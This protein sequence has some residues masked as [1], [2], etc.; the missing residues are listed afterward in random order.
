ML[1]KQQVA[2][3]FSKSAKT[4][5]KISILQRSLAD[6]LFNGSKSL[7]PKNILDLGC[8]TGYLAK[9]LAKKFKKAK[10]IGIDLASGMIKEAK[11]RNQLQNIKYL[12]QDCEELPKIGR[13][14]LIISNASLQWMDLK[15][16]SLCIKRNLASNGIFMFNTF[17]PKNLIELQ[18]AGFKRNIFPSSR[19]IKKIFGNYFKIIKIIRSRHKQKFKNIQA[20]VKHLKDLGANT[21]ALKGKPDIKR[22]RAILKN[23]PT[24]FYATFDVYLGIL[25]NPR[26]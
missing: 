23:S 24:P 22:L 14:D 9:K 19:E 16:I 5:D 21:P 3:R 25:N 2:A 18:Q 8:G 7:N 17:G 20:L 10:V 15:K 6:D 13:F 1:N 11:I 4:Y 12:A 26:Q